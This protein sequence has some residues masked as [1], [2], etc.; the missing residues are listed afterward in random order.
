MTWETRLLRFLLVVILFVLALAGALLYPFSLEFAQNWPELEHLHVPLYV[1]VLVGF[2]P[3]VI[4]IA[5]VFDFLKEIDQGEVF[6]VRTVQIL[7]RLK[8]LIGIFAGYL[9][10]FLVG[11]WAAMRLMDYRLLFG[12]FAIEV[13]ALFLFSVVALFERSFSVALGLRVEHDLTV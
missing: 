9:V 4:A 11:A 3:V 2:V 12:W 6:S 8:L 13:V 1:A 5:L 7:H 10:F